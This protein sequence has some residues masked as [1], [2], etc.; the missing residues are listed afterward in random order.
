MRGPWREGSAAVGEGVPGEPR[1]ALHAKSRAAACC[2]DVLPPRRRGLGGGV[3][4]RGL[5]GMTMARTKR[6]AGPA[7]RRVGGDVRRYDA[8]RV[9]IQA[10]AVPPPPQP[11]FLFWW[12][13]S[14]G[15]RSA[16]EREGGCLSVGWL[17]PPVVY[18]HS[19]RGRSR[20]VAA[21]A[22]RFPL[23]PAVR[24]AAAAGA[25]A[26]PRRRR[27]RNGA[28][29]GATAPLPRATV[30]GAWGRDV[31]REA[32]G[33]AP[34][35]R[36]GGGSPAA[37]FGKRSVSRLEPAVAVCSATKIKRVAHGDWVG[38]LVPRVGIGLR[39]LSAPSR[40][41]RR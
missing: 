11:L 3:G 32:G 20:R 27:R 12:R 38:R 33:R 8:R 36:W 5:L 30:Q 19:G 2:Q 16:G 18:R 24:A 41:G 31:R 15:S 1:G 17:F 13:A 25:R 14:R 28:K 35:Q 29:G 7:A 4:Q 9:C 40:R 22:F 21:L 34:G 23:S 10:V 37:S 6:V 39:W 26:L